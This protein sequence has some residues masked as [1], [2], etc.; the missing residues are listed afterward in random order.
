MVLEEM[1]SQAKYSVMGKVGPSTLKIM[2]CSSM[3]ITRE[4]FAGVEKFSNFGI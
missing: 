4:K 1:H 2:Y 3:Y